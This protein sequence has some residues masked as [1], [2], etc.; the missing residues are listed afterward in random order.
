MK[1][2]HL[3]DPALSLEGL[4][5]SDREGRRYWR[6]PADVI[7]QVNSGVSEVAKF[8]SG[9][10]VRFATD[11]R[12]IALCA[13][14]GPAGYIKN[15]GAIGKCGLAGYVDGEWHYVVYPAASDAEEMTGAY[16]LDGKMHEHTV[17]LPLF[18]PLYDLMIGLDDDAQ[19]KP[20]RPYAVQKPIVFYG[21]SITN[22]ASAT[23]A[24]NAYVSI[25]CRRL[26]AS[27]LNLGFSGSARGEE[28]IARYIAG[29]DM[30]LFVMDYDHN[31]PDAAHL[32]ATHERFFRIVREAQ[33][34]LPIALI[35]KP[36]FDIDPEGN[37]ARRA[38]IRRTYEH[39]LAAGDARVRF[40]DGETLFGTTER[41]DC[42]VDGTHPND[43]GFRRMAD[44]ITPVLRELLG[45]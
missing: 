22:G 38:V 24:G 40:I 35:S 10:R 1:W 37:A 21:S 4:A 17:Y 2:Y 27:F 34:D 43:L 16:D 26:D 25:V 15:V 5:L 13:V 28:S 20:P 19:V 42:L 18:T 45:L 36:D 9:A 8:P 11:S 3:T 14:V 39:A 31:A 30:S 44:A 32:E 33:P 23:H 41:R 6:L 12:R 7:D 29:L